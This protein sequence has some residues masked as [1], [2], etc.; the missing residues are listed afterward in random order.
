METLNTMNERFPGIEED[1][2]NPEQH[3]TEPTLAELF[4]GAEEG[5]THIPDEIEVTDL[6]E[7]I[8]ATGLSPEALAQYRIGHTAE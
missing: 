8:S 4:A 3:E 1:V 5:M 2:L 7:V 6:N